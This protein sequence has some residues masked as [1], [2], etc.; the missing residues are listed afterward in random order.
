MFL[1]VNIDFKGEEA[2]IRDATKAEAVIKKNIKMCSLLLVCIVLE[3][4]KTHTVL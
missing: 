3:V 1:S 2:V 4:T